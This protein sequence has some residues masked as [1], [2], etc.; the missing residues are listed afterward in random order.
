MTASP[1]PPVPSGRHGNPR[2][3]P[4]LAQHALK[5]IAGKSERA[6]AGTRPGS[7]LGGVREPGRVGLGIARGSCFDSYLRLNCW[8]ARASGGVARHAQS[9]LHYVLK[10]DL[11]LTPN[12]SLN[13]SVV[14]SEKSCNVCCVSPTLGMPKSPP[15]LVEGDS[16]CVTSPSAW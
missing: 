16:P 5:C 14:F 2:C 3:H 12:C 13:Y 11:T 15:F 7:L 10:M 1:Y 4:A 6:G 9:Q 8:G